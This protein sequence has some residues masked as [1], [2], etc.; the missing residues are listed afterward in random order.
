MN[1]LVDNTTYNHPLHVLA[2]LCWIK[3]PSD[4]QRLAGGLLLEPEGLRSV[5]LV[6]GR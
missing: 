3:A 2:E 4:G 5:E 1:S 6:D